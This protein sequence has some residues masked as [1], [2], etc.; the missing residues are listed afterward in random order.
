MEVVFALVLR[1]LILN[2]VDLKGSILDP[3]CAASD[4][5]AMVSAVAHVLIKAL[6]SEH[7]IRRLAVLI[8]YDQVLDYGS[9]SHYGCLI[10]AFHRHGECL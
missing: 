10:T 9:V 3:V 5:C 1:D 4:D 6:A 8:R 7:D 2:A